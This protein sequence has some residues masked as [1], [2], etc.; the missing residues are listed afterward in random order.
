VVLRVTQA[1][2]AA[3]ASGKQKLNDNQL[4][5]IQLL[6]RAIR[7]KPAEAKEMPKAAGTFAGT[8]RTALKKYLLDAGWLREENDDRARSKIGKT[9]DALT[10]KGAI[11]FDAKVV[12]L[13]A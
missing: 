7:E 11:N 9:L 2:V 5:F 10:R 12:W 3:E 1:T 4:R 13:Q 8:T 6:Q